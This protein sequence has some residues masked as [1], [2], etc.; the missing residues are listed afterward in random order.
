MAR[1]SASHRPA[2]PGAQGHLVRDPGDPAQPAGQGAEAPDGQGGA[3]GGRPDPRPDPEAVQASHGAELLGGA[4]GEG[5]DHLRG[6]DCDCPGA[7]FDS[8]LFDGC[9]LG[10]KIGDLYRTL[11]S[12]SSQLFSFF[13][14]KIMV[15]RMPF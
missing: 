10:E 11:V 13:F 15:A 9:A 14:R 7:V 12:H 4:V 3:P 2:R 5:A 8:V 1:R 6:G